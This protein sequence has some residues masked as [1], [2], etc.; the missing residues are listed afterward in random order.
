MD[1]QAS[2]AEQIEYWNGP[3]ADRWVAEQENLD[4]ALSDFGAGLLERAGLNPGQKVLDIGCGCA[5]VTLAAADQVGATGR[6]VG[7]DVSAPMLAHARKRAAGRPNVTLLEADASKADFGADA[8]FDVAISR[9]GVMFFGDPTAAFTH[10]RSALAPKASVVFVCWRPVADNE[11]VRVP[12]EVVCQH[13]TP[14]PRPGPDDPGPF[15]FGDP[16]RVRRILTGAGFHDPAIVRFD[17][18]VFLSES[19]L[20]PAVSMASTTGP[21][22]RLL[23]D[24]PEDAR[25]RALEG[26]RARLQHFVHGDR[27]TMDG[28]VWLVSATS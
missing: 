24:A 22:G 7:V 11:W 2:H 13:V 16:V 27:V 14:G 17:A 25:A 9:F 28:S 18:P 4:R 10:I 12:Y 23:R 19:G 15:S 21:S 8:P 5:T 26:L 6:V 20:E 3:Q 1:P